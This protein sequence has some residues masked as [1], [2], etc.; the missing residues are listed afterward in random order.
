VRVRLEELDLHELLQL[1]PAGG[2]LRFAGQ[3]AL[4]V[5]ASALGILRQQLVGALGWGRA[6]ALLLRFGYAQGWRTAESLRDELPWEGEEDWRQAGA[7]LDAMRGLVRSEPLAPPPEPEAVAHALWRDSYEAEQHLLRL[8][9]SEEPVCWTLAGFAS[10]Y[11]SF[12]HG[13]EV[14]AREKTCVGAGH[15]ACR[16]V[17]RPREEWASLVPGT[18]P[19]AAY[20]PGP[21]RDWF[22][23]GAAPPAR[24]HPRE[25]RGDGDWEAI[26]GG[27]VARS[28]PMRRALDL[29]RRLAAVDTTVLLTGESGVGKERVARLVHLASPRAARPFVAVPCGAIPE[30]LVEAELFGHVRGAFT[31]ASADRTG[32]LEEASG[33]TLFL[34]EVG[35]L[36]LSVQPKL[37]RALEEREVRRVGE[38]RARPVDLRLMAAT[39]RDLEEEAAAGRF[40]RDLLYRLKVVELPIPPLRER[41]EDVL[42]LARAALEAASRRLGRPL[43]GL[44][45]RAADQLARYAW[46]GNVRELWNAME[47]A[48]VLAEGGQVDLQDLPEDVRAAVPAAAGAPARPLQRVERDYVL[49]ALRQNQGHRARTARQLG[50]GE[51]T[52]YR[53]LRAWRSRT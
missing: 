24:P 50:I 25:R 36:P 44:A 49:A 9:R 35:E 18:D 42:P 5:D 20:G 12:V 19:T 1:E 38:S 51:A 23:P 52:L 37:L 7:R 13:R 29:A 8:G 14:L 15:D 26:P 53:R 21:F 41:P 32:L 6:R 31:G 33:G 17:A 46:P 43:G 10:G 40:R 4:L 16:V 48:A 34:D 27:V 39:N 45:P 2:V 22:D 3:R 30:A 11:L 28:E 47:R